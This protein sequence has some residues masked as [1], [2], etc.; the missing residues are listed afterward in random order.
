ML[1]S[2]ET[3]PQTKKS[4]Q[5]ARRQSRVQFQTPEASVVSEAS[6]PHQD[7]RNNSSKAGSTPF[8]AKLK[9]RVSFATHGKA[10]EQKSASSIAEQASAAKSETESSFALATQWLDSTADPGPS[11]IMAAEAG[12]SLDQGDINAAGPVSPRTVS[13][14]AIAEGDLDEDDD[15]CSPGTVSV[16]AGSTPYL[17]RRMLSA[18]LRSTTPESG[19]LQEGSGEG[20]E[21][22]AGVAL[23]SMMAHLLS[24]EWDERDEHVDDLTGFD[25]VSSLC[26]TW[27]APAA[28]ALH[29]HTMQPATSLV[30]QAPPCLVK[31]CSTVGIAIC[32]FNCAIYF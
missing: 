19:S 14:Q 23:T 20:A 29:L 21:C 2:A 32:S 25:Q 27:T 10:A 9:R 7:E 13:A 22:E 28:P 11:I 31:C 12:T 8:Q 16:S 5:Q 1:A 30:S 18:A 4:E 24:K 26:T 3:L 15:S 17:N 6:D